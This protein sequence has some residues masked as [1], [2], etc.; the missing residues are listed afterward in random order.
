[1]WH[2]LEELQKAP[3]TNE[4]L[5]NARHALIGNYTL[6]TQTASSRIV[7]A[8]NSYLLNRPI[9]FIPIYRE[10]LQSI[11]PE[12]LLDIARKT[13]RREAATLGMIR[14]SVDGTQ[15]EKEVMNHDGL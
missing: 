14:G 12:Q 10:I 1:M 13:F 6:N 8:L 4:E 5:E 7:E 2:E 11:Q 3:V 15:A 9:P